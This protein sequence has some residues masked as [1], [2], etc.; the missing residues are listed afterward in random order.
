MGK[1]T[2]PNSD[3]NVG[4]HPAGKVGLDGSPP[5]QAHVG[6]TIVRLEQSDVGGTIPFLQLSQLFQSVVP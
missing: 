3:I 5:V 2:D 1:N 4:E 6:R